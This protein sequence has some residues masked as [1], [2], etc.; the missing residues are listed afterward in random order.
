[1]LLLV[2]LG[3]VVGTETTWEAEG[4][5]GGAT[6]SGVATTGGAV[7]EMGHVLVGGGAGVIVITAGC[8]DTYLQ[9][10]QA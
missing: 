3:A 1:M 7:I 4:V 2:A 8:W 10:Q 6:G 9:P 5:A